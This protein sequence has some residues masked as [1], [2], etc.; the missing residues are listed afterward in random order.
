VLAV[1]FDSERTAR[2]FISDGQYTVPVLL[3]TEHRV[4]RTYKVSGIPANVLVDHEGVVRYAH[5]GYGPGYERV[6]I[7]EIEQLLRE[8]SH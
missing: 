4:R 5:I 8:A 1:S 2:K 7:S 3:D 6:L